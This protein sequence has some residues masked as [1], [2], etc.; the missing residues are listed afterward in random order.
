MLG[1]KLQVQRGIGNIAQ[2]GAGGR[3]FARAT[4][5]EEG[6]ADDVPADKD[7]IEHVVDT[8]QDVGVRNQRRI[9]RDLDARGLGALAFAFLEPLRSRSVELRSGA[10]SLM[11]PSSLMV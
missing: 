9:Y 6:V 5:V 2:H 10:K 11:M 7:R 1:A 4:T 8:R 3:V